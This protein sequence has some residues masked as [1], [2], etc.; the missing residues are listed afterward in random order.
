MN[1]WDIAKLTLAQYKD[2]LSQDSYNKI[3]ESY[4]ETLEADANARRAKVAED[5]ISMSRLK[6]SISKLE[7]QYKLI[8]SEV[9][10]IRAL[11]EMIYNAKNE[12]R[13]ISIRKNH[14][15]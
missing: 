12:I 2:R 10:K 9:G 3:V 5:I 8:Q 1:F 4:Y 6:I 14:K 15:C 13:A 11:E 7:R